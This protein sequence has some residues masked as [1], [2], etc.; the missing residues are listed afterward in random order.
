MWKCLAAFCILLPLKAIGQ[1]TG[2][3]SV[4][5]EPKTGVSAILGKL[6]WGSSKAQVLDDAKARL[7]GAWRAEVKKLDALGVDKLRKAKQREFKQIESSYTH[8]IGRSS[9]LETSMLAQELSR[10]LGDA[11]IEQSVK[12]QKR[13]YFL[14]DDRLW[15]LSL[16]HI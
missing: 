11:I 10:G 8:L 16:I 14:R 4:P 12:G 3:E 7:E 13:Y 9:V 15:K 2:D 1:D 5:T 6:D